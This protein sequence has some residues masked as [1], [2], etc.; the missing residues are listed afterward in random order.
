MGEVAGVGVQVA[1]A[2]VGREA[3]MEAVER[4]VETGEKVACVVRGVEHEP[5]RQHL[6]WPKNPC[7]QRNLC[8]QLL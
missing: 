7:D 4:G 2:V 1:A 5:F 8:H 3:R 6:Y